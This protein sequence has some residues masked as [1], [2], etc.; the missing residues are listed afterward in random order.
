MQALAARSVRAVGT[1]QISPFR[2]YLGSK[3]RYSPVTHL[4]EP[5]IIKPYPTA[6]YAPVDKNNVKRVTTK[7][8]MECICELNRTGANIE[9]LVDILD[10]EGKE[11]VDIGFASASFENVRDLERC[12]KILMYGSSENEFLR[13]VF[14]RDNE[15]AMD[16]H[17]FGNAF[18]T[19]YCKL[20]DEKYRRNE[21]LIKLV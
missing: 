19:L 13:F 2:R 3:S 11:I 15:S 10:V 14:L 1:M 7:A 6:S 8:F 16:W 4:E 17:P 12:K 21:K 9:V 18:Q 5:L 20:H